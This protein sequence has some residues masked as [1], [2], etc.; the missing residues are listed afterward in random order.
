MTTPI[1]ATDEEFA[2]RVLNADGLVMVEFWATWCASC[3]MLAPILEELAAD[4]AGRVSIVK[5]NVDEN[6]DYASQYQVRRTPTIVFFR[7]GVELDRII[8][9]GKKA[10]YAGKLEA[11]LG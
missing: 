1:A 5:V 4:Y 11:L 8:G 2:Q 6:P 7:D 9:A 3:R 10:H